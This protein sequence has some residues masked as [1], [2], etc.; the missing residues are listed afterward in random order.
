MAPAAAI[1]MQEHATAASLPV[2]ALLAGGEPV[3][4]RGGAGSWA[5]V[6]AG[7]RGPQAAMDYLR[8]FDAG[9]ALQY[10]YVPAG[11]GGRP[12]Y[13]HDFTELNFE[14]RRGTLSDVLDGVAA[15]LDDA[16]PPTFYLSSLPVDIGLP[17]FRADNDLDLAAAGIASTPSIWIG[18]RVT[19]S[20]HYDVP[21]NL[22]CCVA[23]RRRFTVFPPD[24]IANLYPGPLEPTPGG[25]VV[26]VVDF[27]NPDFARY[28]RFRAA[29]EHARTVVLDPGDVLFIPSM[30]WH[31]VEGLDAFNVLVNYWWNGAPAQLPMPVPA[32]YHAIWAIRDR[33]QHEKDAWREVFE[34]YVFGPAGLAAEHLPEPAR[35]LLG[36]V[37]ETLARQL[38]AM[39]IGKLNR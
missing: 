17:G 11:S 5:A 6:A 12:F 13:T 21:N 23:G 14:V 16:R 30:W 10:S 38:R 27:A 34:Y 33:P 37:D 18:N 8:R 35:N 31:H 20:C 4:L 22:A 24:Q 36:P 32:L 29:L 2:G 1:A 3:V 28:P 19:A 39:L 7:R 26:S 9:K 15:H 25:Q